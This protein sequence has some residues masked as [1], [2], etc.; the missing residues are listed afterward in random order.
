MTGRWPYPGDSPLARAR[1]LAG[2][3]RAALQTANPAACTDLDNLAQRWGET[4]LAP[5][6]A[7]HNLDDW[8]SPADAADLA[9][10]TTNTLRQWRHRGRLT[11]R[12]QPDGTWQ[13]Q[14]REILA[15]LA[16]RRRRP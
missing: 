12:Q 7:R 13:Y 2:A 6:P 10:V 14:G 1:R 15:L 16:E 4:W 3:Y 5:T 11:G 9:A 8:L